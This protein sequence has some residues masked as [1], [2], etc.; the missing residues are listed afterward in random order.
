MKDSTKNAVIIV[1]ISVIVVLSV[2][3]YQ[4]QKT[5]ESQRTTIANQETQITE[6]KAENAKLSEVTPEKIM[7][8]AKELIKEEGVNLLESLTDKAIQEIQNQ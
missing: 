8:N 7:D 4:A 6:L 2:L 5:I 3:L 1:S